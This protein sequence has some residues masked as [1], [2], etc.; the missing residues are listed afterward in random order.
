M[1][2][3]I[4]KHQKTSRNIYVYIFVKNKEEAIKKFKAQR[5]SSDIL[6]KYINPRGEYENVYDINDLQNCYFKL[7]KLLEQYNYLKNQ[8]DITQFQTEYLM[9][10]KYVFIP[11]FHQQLFILK[12]QELIDKGNKNILVGAIPR[13]GKSYIMAGSILEYVKNNEIK[14]PGKKIKFLMIT[15]APNE[16]FPEYKNIFD[17]YSDFDKLGIDV[18]FRTSDTTKEDVSKCLSSK[19]RHCVIIISKQT[20]GWVSQNQDEEEETQEAEDVNKITERIYKLLGK[21]PNINVMFLDEAHFG[22]STEKAQKIFN[23]IW[24]KIL[25]QYM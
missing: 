3:L 2:T 14:N 25:L 17:T 24:K 6:I 20:L 1:C 21:N 12:I 8:D 10:L 15:P 23:S 18:I 5:K 9:V 19:D 16:T 4:E 22:M 11:R 7:K 13:S